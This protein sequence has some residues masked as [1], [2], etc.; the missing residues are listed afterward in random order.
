MDFDRYAY[1]YLTSAAAILIIAGTVFF[2]IV[3]KFSWVNAYYF[4]VV[5]LTTIGYG[6]VVPHTYLGKIATTIYI[7]LG[8]GI[9][10][11][12]FSV[13]VKR[14]GAKFR[15]RHDPKGEGHNRQ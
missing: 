10:S 15:S 5:T 9:I 1:R 12:Y 4:C 14:R 3:E 7:V 13:R 11:T 2:H 6:D 8:L